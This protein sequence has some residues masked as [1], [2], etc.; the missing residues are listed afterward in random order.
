MVKAPVLNVRF[1]DE[2]REALEKAAIADGRS[3]SAMVER[4]VAGWLRDQGYM[5]VAKKRR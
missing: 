4:I 5:P 3:L 2:T 1:Q